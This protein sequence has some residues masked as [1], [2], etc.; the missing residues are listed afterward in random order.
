MT[1]KIKELTE[2]I[3]DEGIAKA[4][5]EACQIIADANSEA[6][7]TIQS[8]KKQELEIVETAKKKAA[9]YKK[10]IDSELQ[11][12]A[13]QFISNLK[14]QI[15][16]LI[17]AEQVEAPVKEAFKDN[18]FI[19]KIVLT[20]INNW[21]PQNPEELK[22]NILL[23]K[24]DEKSLN[25]FFEKKALDY[26]NKGINIQIDPKISKGFKIG[27]KDGS[28]LINFTDTDFEEYFKGYLKDKTKKLLFSSE[29]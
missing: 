6:E 23:P 21:N 24:E 17:T 27:P 5:Q 2:K 29:N 15:A 11:L 19:K 8:A 12:A 4:K 25:L 9:E 16:K 18:E 13:R 14:L 7:K 22:L 28:Y 20:L 3:Y 26:L 1:N 10:N